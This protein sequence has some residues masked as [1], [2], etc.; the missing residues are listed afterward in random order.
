VSLEWSLFEERDR[1]PMSAEMF[2][3]LL[4]ARLRSSGVRVERERRL[5]LRIQVG[6]VSQVADLS[7]YYEQYRSEPIELSQI[8]QPLVDRVAKGQAAGEISDSYEQA[9]QALMPLLV[10][11]ID[12]ERKLEEGVQMVVRPFVPDVGVALV[13]DEK[14]SIIFVVPEALVRWNV[15]LESAFDT[16]LRNLELEARGHQFSQTGAG[17]RTILIDRSTEGYAATRAILPSR[18]EDWERRVQG[19]LVLGLPTRDFM[20]GFGALHPN[21]DSL[22]AQIEEDA[23]L[24]AHGI[25]KSLLVYRAGKLVPFRPEVEGA[26]TWTGGSDVAV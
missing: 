19:E 10:S 20:I 23:T 21:L 26:T 5:A 1:P 11:A 18:L 7:G 24:H 14:D 16:A 15:S 9:A 12:W 4:V 6:D 2:T 22:S 13:T 17:T 3:T 8:I 25:C